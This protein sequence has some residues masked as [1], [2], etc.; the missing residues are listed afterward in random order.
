MQK[1]ITLGQKQG[2]NPDLHKCVRGIGYGCPTS[3]WLKPFS[4][5]IVLY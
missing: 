3:P 5:L 1:Q 2:T 4:L